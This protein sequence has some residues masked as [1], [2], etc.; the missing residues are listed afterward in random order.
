MTTAAA[1]LPERHDVPTLRWRREVALA[2]GLYGVYSLIRDLQGSA[3]VSYQPAVANATKVIVIEQATGLL[4]EAA[5]QHLALQARW[6]IELA[7]ILYGSLH[8]VVTIAVVVALYRTSAPAYRRAR[9]ALAITTL[10]AL[11]GFTL[12]PMAPPRLLPASYGFVDTLAR[13][14]TLWS[15]HNGPVSQLSNQY[16]AMPSLHFGWALWCTL[17]VLPIVHSRALR[18][19]VCTYPM[20][21]LVVIIITANHLILDAVAG[22]AIVG[23]GFAVSQMMSRPRT[24]G[25]V[26][27][28]TA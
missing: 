14:G 7:N 4:H 17:A 9:N 28:R 25:V 5:L 21:T 3:A 1:E 16:A 12:F 15:F 27:T 18:I 22:A 8:F 26:T 10:L 20:V 23:V 2:L 19:A 11:I 6:L 13:F 24:V